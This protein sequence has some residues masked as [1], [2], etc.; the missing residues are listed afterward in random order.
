MLI[1]LVQ[2]QASMQTRKSIQLH[3]SIKQEFDKIPG[4][5]SDQKMKELLVVYTN[6]R[7][8]EP[9]YTKLLNM[10]MIKIEDVLKSHGFEQQNLFKDLS[11]LSTTMNR[12]LGK[13][14]AQDYNPHV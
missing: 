4:D 1:K 13:I 6:R 5:S 3:E 9:A 8:S 12:L 11:E 7:L 2:L 10:H 14:E